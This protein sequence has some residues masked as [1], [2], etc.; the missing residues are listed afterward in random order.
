MK[1]YKA[2]VFKE[3]IWFTKDNTVS[4]A[5]QQFKDRIKESKKQNIN[6]KLFQIEEVVNEIPCNNV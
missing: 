5:E 4:G 3:E 2:I 1:S 6:Y